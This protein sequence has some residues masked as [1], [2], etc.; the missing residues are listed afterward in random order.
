VSGAKGLISLNALANGGGTFRGDERKLVVCRK[1][2]GEIIHASRDVDDEENT[3][4]MKEGPKG[5][6]I[7]RYG[8]QHDE[9]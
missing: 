8:I 9:S 7:E 2:G 1:E 6:L 3:K 5:E 4:Q